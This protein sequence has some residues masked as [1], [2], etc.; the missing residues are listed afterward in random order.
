MFCS[1]C[2][3]EIADGSV[4]CASCGASQ[5]GTVVSARNQSN[6][7]Q[8]TLAA[9]KEVI[10]E[11]DRM[12]QHFEQKREQYNQYDDLVDTVVKKVRRA[13]VP[14]LVWG[15][16]IASCGIIDVAMMGG[17]AKTVPVL[18]VSLSVGLLM[19]GGHIAINAT[20]S[21][22]VKV[23]YAELCN[24]REELETHYKAFGP[25]LIGMTYT[26]PSIL[27]TIKETIQDGRAD[28]P[29]DAINILLDDVHKDEMEALAEQT[30]IATEMA[31]SNAGNASFFAAANFFLK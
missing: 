17:G 30:L 21:K 3:T 4:F 29:R 11:M 1:S 10:E 22:Q 20:R 19:I 9:R 13:A 27:A 31:A 24:I 8:S 28:S 18:A 6:S 15:I 16:I 26:N 2:G 5:S 12:I 23:M 25:C 14:L 7:I